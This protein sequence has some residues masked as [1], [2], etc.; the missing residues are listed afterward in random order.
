LGYES[1]REYA[2]NLAYNG[3]FA[4]A[5]KRL[6]EAAQ[7][8]PDDLPIRG[9]HAAFDYGLGNYQGTRDQLV[10]VA[11]GRIRPTAGLALHA[12]A[13]VHLGDRATAEKLLTEFDGYEKA[14]RLPPDPFHYAVIHFALGDEAKAYAEL[15]QCVDKRSTLAMT[16]AGQ[17]V[18]AAQR[19]DPR[20][21]ALVE[22]VAMAKPVSTP[23]ANP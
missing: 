1:V 19:K 15:A 2:I 9:I 22:R 13:R 7:L 20:Y 5:Q 3:R 6:D 21:Q 11:E 12:A 18:F 16:L 8:I 14:K 17:P 23:K 10:S 4:D